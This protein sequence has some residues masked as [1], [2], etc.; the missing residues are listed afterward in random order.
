MNELLTLTN[1]V[2]RGVNLNKALPLDNGRNSKEHLFI[3]NLRNKKFTSDEQA[4][5]ELYG[6]NQGDVRYKMLKHRLK[7]KLYNSLLFIDYNKIGLK[8][9]NQKE[10]ECMTLLH[11]ALILRRQYE[12][13]MVIN[14]ANKVITIA[15]RLDFTHHIVTALELKT[16]CYSENGNVKL[17]NKSSKL[18]KSYLRVRNKEIEA[19]YLFQTVVINLKKSVTTRKKLLPQVPDIV[20]K[21]ESLWRETKSNN[22]FDAYYK[23]AISYYELSGDFDR[24]VEMTISSLKWVKEGLVNATLFNSNYNKFVLVYAHLRSKKYAA[25]LKYAESYAND[26]KYSSVNWFPFMENYYLLALHSKQ[27]DLSSLLLQRVFNNPSFKIISNAAKERW[28]LYRAYFDLVSPAPDADVT[29]IKNPYSLSLPEYSKDKLGFN[30]AILIL[31]FIY[32]LKKEDSEALLYRI[33]SLKKYILTHL[34]DTFSTRSKT[35]LKLLIL[36]VTEDY[37]ADTCRKKGQKLYVKLTETPPPGDAYAEIEIVPYE[38]LWEYILSILDHQ[39][40]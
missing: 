23:T 24:I 15:E 19:I 20:S 31:Q 39:S 26:F 29:T 17:F 18:L 37:E 28:S 40:K 14:L 38:H 25:G 11:Q 35:F 7:K 5:K 32:Y 4:A 34:K 10:H 1:L 30:V 21:L 27:Y 12:L 8:E 22:I 13:D 33:E 36:T 6:S 9:Y 3:E 2:T 16:S